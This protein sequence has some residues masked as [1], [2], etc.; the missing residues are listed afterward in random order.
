M[1]TENE[2]E[3]EGL[4]RAYNLVT[5]VEAQNTIARAIASKIDAEKLK[6]DAEKLKV[7]AEKLKIDT[8]RIIAE[9]VAIYPNRND[10]AAREQYISRRTVL[11]SL[12]RFFT[13][14]ISRLNCI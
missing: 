9:S 6:I 7:D 5:S 8:E 11:S 10:S 13:Y 3:L 1:P 14:F 2:G 12:E 4:L